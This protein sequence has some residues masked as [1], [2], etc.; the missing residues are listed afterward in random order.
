MVSAFPRQRRTNGIDWV[1]IFLPLAGAVRRMR[2]TVYRASIPVRPRAKPRKPEPQSLR[3]SFSTPITPNGVADRYPHGE[4]APQKAEVL[5]RDMTTSET[6]FHRL[7]FMVRRLAHAATSDGT[8]S[9]TN[10]TGRGSAMPASDRRLDSAC[11]G[12]R[13][14]HARSRD[15][16]AVKRLAGSARCMAKSDVT[17]K[18]RGEVDILGSCQWRSSSGQAPKIVN[19]FDPVGLGAR[20]FPEDKINVALSSTRGEAGNDDCGAALGDKAVGQC[21]CRNGFP[22]S[23]E[24]IPRAG[25]LGCRC[26]GGVQCISLA[27]VKDI[28]TIH[29][30][31]AYC[32]RLRL[33][34][35]PLLSLQ[36]RGFQRQ[37][38]V[39]SRHARAIEPPAEP[40]G[41]LARLRRERPHGMVGPVDRL[42]VPPQ[43]QGHA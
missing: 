39:Q 17:G 34:R 8:R 25:E 35:E 7:L 24:V 28:R 1:A 15:K 21:P 38:S 11:G 12:R 37:G 20:P 40:A 29:P 2:P 41:A 22:L 19:N 16:L 43:R 5:E 26:A 4:A 36:P 31:A 6:L 27:K 42:G 3:A 10:M 14:K 30:V 18:G 13:T 9:R 33:E 23:G 32:H